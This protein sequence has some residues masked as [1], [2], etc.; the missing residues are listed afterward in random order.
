[1]AKLLNCRSVEQNEMEF[2]PKAGIMWNYSQTP[3]PLRLTL[4][5]E[6]HTN[7]P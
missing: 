4:Q 3:L 5:Q 7:W 2:Y 1:M 6:Q